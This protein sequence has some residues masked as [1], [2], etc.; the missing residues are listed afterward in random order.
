[1]VVSE[2]AQMTAEQRTDVVVV[3]MVERRRRDISVECCIATTGHRGHHRCYQKLRSLSFSFHCLSDSLDVSLTTRTI[4]RTQLTN[5]VL[6]GDMERSPFSVG[7]SKK[8][9]ACRKVFF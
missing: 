3:L 8:F 6:A 5:G 2:L 9:N 1:M 7:L 4:E